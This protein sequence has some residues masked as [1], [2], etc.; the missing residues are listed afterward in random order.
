MLN[1]R[2]AIKSAGLLSGALA[3]PATAR[4]L[5]SVPPAVPC[6]RCAYQQRQLREV[7]AVARHFADQLEAS[8][9][10]EQHK[11]MVAYADA[12]TDELIAEQDQY[13]DELAATCPAWRLRSTW[14]ASISL[15]SELT[16]WGATARPD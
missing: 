5:E 14:W 6:P 9:T 2:A 4:A 15:A 7:S 8:L 3:L 1:R 11:L 12:R 10:P 16:T 13:V